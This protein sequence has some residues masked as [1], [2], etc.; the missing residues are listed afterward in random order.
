[1]KE[2]EIL[3]KKRGSQKL[4]VFPCAKNFLLMYL[5]HDHISV[6]IESCLYT[7]ISELFLQNIMYLISL[8]LF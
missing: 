3:C 4:K 2:Q 7:Y 5:Y 1:M 6:S 8:L